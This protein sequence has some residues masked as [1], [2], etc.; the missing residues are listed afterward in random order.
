MKQSDE[1]EEDNFVSISFELRK[2]V[3][4]GVQFWS[5][6]LSSSFS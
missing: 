3:K 6:S 5:S 1:E 2:K 4:K